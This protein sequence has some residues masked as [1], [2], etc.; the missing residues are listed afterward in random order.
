[1]V[2]FHS[3]DH[4]YGKPLWGRPCLGEYLL[5]IPLNGEEHYTRDILL[6]HIFHISLVKASRKLPKNSSFQQLSRK[7]SD[8]VKLEK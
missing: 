3:I 1:M 5:Q 6:H 4:I 8:I 2:I 7:P